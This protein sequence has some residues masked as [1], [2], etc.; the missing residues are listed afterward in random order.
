MKIA[1]LFALGFEEVEAMS[2]VDVLRRA[3]FDV[4]TAGVGG[5]SITAAHQVTIL[6]DTI[7]EKLDAAQLD[8]VVLPGGMPGAAN[9]RDSTIV[10]DLLKE[11]AAAGKWICAICAAPMVLQEAGLIGNRRFTCYPGFEKECGDGIHTGER[12]TVDGRLITGK[13]PGAALEFAL[14][15][16]RQFGKPQI[17]AQLHDGMLVS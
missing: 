2:I 4:I 1:V 8:A 3:E 9:L 14:E 17:A 12:V 11:M 6:T 7:V 5:T 15:L 13:G 16:V 10:I